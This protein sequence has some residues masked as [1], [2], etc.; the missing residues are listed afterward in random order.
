MSKDDSTQEV[1]LLHLP[2]QYEVTVFPSSCGEYV[3]IQQD[4]CGDYEMTETI[5][6]SRA[7]CAAIWPVLQAFAEFK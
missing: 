1:A 2:L 3:K 6:L 5:E 4:I 7:Q